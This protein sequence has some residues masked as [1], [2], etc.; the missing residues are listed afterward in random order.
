MK[1]FSEVPNRWCGSW[2]RSQGSSGQLSVTLSSESGTPSL[3][4]ECGFPASRLPSLGSGTLPFFDL[5]APTYHEELINT[6]G[7]KDPT[8]SVSTMCQV[9]CTHYATA[10]C[11][12]CK[13]QSNYLR[14][15][16][17]ETKV[18]QEFKLI[19]IWLHTP[20]ASLIISPPTVRQLRNKI[21][22]V[23]Q[24]SPEKRN[25]QD[26]Y[27]DRQIDRQTGR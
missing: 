15:V 22:F 2:G 9:L 12:W 16:L 4:V 7:R 3:R 25:Q 17:E 6:K 21:W 19:K 1:Y 27:I 24:N 14:L 18:P 8:F 10:L 26:R 11:C 20:F 23:S 5:T 13:Q